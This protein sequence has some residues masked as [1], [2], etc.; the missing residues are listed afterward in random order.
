MNQMQQIKC[1]LIDDAL[2]EKTCH[3]I[4]HHNSAKLCAYT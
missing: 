2:Y 3:D 1:T 4:H